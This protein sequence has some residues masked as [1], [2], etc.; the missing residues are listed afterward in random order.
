MKKNILK[1]FR[2]SVRVWMLGSFLFTVGSGLLSAAPNDLATPLPAPAFSAVSFSGKSV[3]SAQL[4][5]KA[6]IVNFFASWCPP[7]RGE[8][9][10]MVALQSKYG[11]KGFTFIGVGYN[12]KESSIRDFTARSGVNYPV[13]M[14]N[15]KLASSFAVLLNGGKFEGIP[16][17]FVVNSSGKVT[18]IILGGRSKEVF[19]SI[20]LDLLKKPV[21]A[22]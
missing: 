18:Q 16:T 12:D 3:G 17:S 19:E 4:A 13:F 20:I 2:H 11:S 7:C 15:E 22:K 5:G 10:D 14:A 1:F 8:V 21:S 6:Y 9:P